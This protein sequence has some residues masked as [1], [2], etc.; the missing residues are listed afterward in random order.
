MI[1]LLQGRLVR[2]AAVDP[3]EMSRMTSTWYRDS[4]LVRLMDA[5]PGPLRSAS[6]TKNWVEKHLDGL[7]DK[8]H[9]FAIRSLQDDS[10]LGD[11]GLDVIDGARRDA[12]VG[13]AIY[14]REFWGRGYGTEAMQLI[15]EYAF[16]QVNLRRVTL[17]VFEYNPRAVHSYEKAGFRHEGRMRQALLREGK[18]W[19]LIYMGIL[20]EEWMEKYDHQTND[21]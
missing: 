7:G 21:Q 19:D 1:A 4:E 17:S 5:R 10:L 18:R 15:L 9:W 14:Q 16:T 11:I 2:L 8:E 6:A 13:I 20:R 12:Y 3:E